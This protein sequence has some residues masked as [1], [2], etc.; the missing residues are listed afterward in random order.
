L[1][2]SAIDRLTGPVQSDYYLRRTRHTQH[3]SDASA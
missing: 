1:K 2:L 3:S